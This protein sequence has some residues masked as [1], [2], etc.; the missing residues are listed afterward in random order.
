MS[1]SLQKIAEETVYD[2]LFELGDELGIEIKQIPEV[3]YINASSKFENLGVDKRYNSLFSE[4]KNEK[5]NASILG[6]PKVII[7]SSVKKSSLAEEV[8]HFIHREYLNLKYETMEE[9]FAF[10]ALKEMIGFFCSKLIDSS[11]VNPFKNIEDFFPKKFNKKKF[12]SV[13][14]KIAKQENSQFEKEFYAQGYGMGEKMFNKYLSRGLSKRKI[15]NIL[16]NPLDN[17]YET[18][19]QFYKWKYKVLK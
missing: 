18:I 4:I 6:I 12:F 7:T 8:G 19:Y 11:R 5:D 15:K 9:L 1:K 3:Y 17:K 14:N 10:C 13:L 16:T 2:L